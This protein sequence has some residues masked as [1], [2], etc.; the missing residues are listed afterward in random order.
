M[1]NKAQIE[2]L[3]NKLSKLQVYGIVG[4]DIGVIQNPVPLQILQVD[5]HAEK[6]M[7]QRRITVQDA[8]SYIDNAMVMFEQ[9]DGVKRLYVSGDG[10]SVAVVDGG[11]LITAYPVSQFDRAMMEI[12]REV[13]KYV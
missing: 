5:P 10:N 13:K 4:E 9:Q 7:K 12:L 1:L 8:Q 11:I 6:R 3:N 2:G